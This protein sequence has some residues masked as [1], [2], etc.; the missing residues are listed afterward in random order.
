MNKAQIKAELR[1]AAATEDPWFYVKSE[2]YKRTYKYHNSCI[3]EKPEH[4]SYFF[5]FVAEAI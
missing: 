4:V 5:L 3:L 2:A 1:R